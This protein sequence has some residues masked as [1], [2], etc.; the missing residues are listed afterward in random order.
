MPT[1][2]RLE[3]GAFVEVDDSFAAVDADASIPAKGDVLLS[4]ARF[5][6]DGA[7]LL[8]DGRRVGV[9]VQPEEEVEG[10]AYD[11]PRLAVVALMFPKFR[12]GRPYSSAVLLRTRLGFKGELRAVGDVLREQAVQ[13]VRC[14]FDGFVPADGADAA[15]WAAAAGR[16][17]HVYQAAADRRAP[18]FVE[19]ERE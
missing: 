7:A 3:A 8:D 9:L 15:V 19:R 12:D 10:L 17:R 11:L 18:A 1:L 5:E 4:L 16:Y 6:A 13:L 14:G 2:I